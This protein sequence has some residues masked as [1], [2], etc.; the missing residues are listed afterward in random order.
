MHFHLPR[1]LHGWREFA[2][3]VGIIVVGV[4]IALGAEQVVSSVHERS[5]AAQA[6]ENVRAEAAFNL[7]TISDRVATQ[8]CIE[9]RIDELASILAAADDGRIKQRPTWIGHPP[10]GPFFMRRWEAATAS[11]RNSMFDTGEQEQF[12]QLYD[13][14]ARFNEYQAREQQVW[15]D[16]RVLETWRGQLDSSA[17]LSLAK[18]L[19]QA[20]YLAWDLNFAG[21]SALANVQ[22]T[23]IAIPREKSG[24]TS[25]CLPIQT[26]RPD[27]IRRINGPYGQP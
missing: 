11:G 6:R 17:R 7:G 2:G 21:R 3:E 20:K 23:G 24:T 15:A 12:G 14:F 26:S 27:A 16:L 13:I 19:Q 5:E 18:E 22:L 8:S 1:P 4:L 10:T 9:H 25:I